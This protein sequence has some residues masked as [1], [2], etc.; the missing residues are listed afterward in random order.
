MVKD[1]KV[2]GILTEV[3]PHDGSQAVVVGVGLNVNLDPSSAGLPPTATSLSHECGRDLPRGELLAAILD[4]LGSYLGLDDAGFTAQVLDRWQGLLWRRQQAI[5]VDQ[6]GAIIRGVVEGL[7]AS[8]SLRVRT[9]DGMLTEISTG[10][11]LTG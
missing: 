2:C 1:R 7:A 8:G 9:A 5:R 11:V 3:V 6:D 10:D 4:R